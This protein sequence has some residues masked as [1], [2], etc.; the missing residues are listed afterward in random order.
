MCVDQILELIPSK[1]L[2]A[3]FQLTSFEDLKSLCLVNKRMNGL[4]RGLLWRKPNFRFRQLTLEEFKWISR[5]PI[6]VLDISEHFLYTMGEWKGHFGSINLDEASVITL[7]KMIGQMDHLSNLQLNISFTYPKE[8]LLSKLLDQCKIKTLTLRSSLLYD[9]DDQVLGIMDIIRFSK[10]HL[11]YFKYLES[12]IIEEE[13]VD[14]KSYGDYEYQQ[15]SPESC[16]LT[17]LSIKLFTNYFNGYSGLFWVLGY[18]SGLKNLYIHLIMING[19]EFDETEFLKAKS[20]FMDHHPNCQVH[21]KI[22]EF[23]DDSSDDSSDDEC[24]LIENLMI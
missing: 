18:F 3:I 24:N 8:P 21:T 22:D 12:L 5:M 19:W 4:A 23:M 2:E 16:K 10:K 17:N 20:D 13:L 1:I 14:F 6:Q 7:F 15:P 11:P 9:K